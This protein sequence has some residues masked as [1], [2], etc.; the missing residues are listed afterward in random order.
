MAVKYRD[1]D[2]GDTSVAEQFTTQW[3]PQLIEQAN[4]KQE[5]LEE[6]QKKPI[7]NLKLESLLEKLVLTLN[8]LYDLIITF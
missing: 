5:R 1:L 6:L 2:L 4:K 7:S 3:L 8:V